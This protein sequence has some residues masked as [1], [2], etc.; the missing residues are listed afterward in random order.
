MKNKLFL[1]LLAAIGLAGSVQAQTTTFV[2]VANLG[3]GVEV[4]SS[5]GTVKVNATVLTKNQRWTRDRVYILANN[6]IVKSGV[7]LTIEPGT[8]IRAEQAT[9]GQGSGAEAA[10]TPA[11][12]GALVVARG[13]RL[14]AAGTADAPIIFTSIDDPNVPGGIATIPV[15]ENLGSTA[16][17]GSITTNTNSAISNRVHTITGATNVT[18]VIRVT[19]ATGGTT[20]KNLTNGEVFTFTN[21]SFVNATNWYRRVGSTTNWYSHPELTT[22]FSNI[23]AARTLKTGVTPENVA[24]NSQGRPGIYT[25]TGTGNLTGTKGYGAWASEADS[26][27][28]HDGLWGGIV[29]AGNATVVRGYGYN[30]N[31]P[32]VFTNA[33]TTSITVPTIDPATGVVSGTQRGVQQIE[34]MAGFE[35]YAWGGG[36][37]VNPPDDSGILRFISNRYGGFIIA[38][39]AELNSYSFYGVGRGTVLEFLEAWNN[40]DDDFEF[41]GG[42]VNMRYALSLFCG[43]DGLDTDQGFLGAIQYY[44]QIQNNGVGNESGSVVS[45]RSSVNYGDSLTENDGPESENRTVPL[46]TYILSNATLVGRGYGSTGSWSNAIPLSGPN[47]KDNAGARW[48]NSIIMDNPHGAVLITDRE[49][50][51]AIDVTTALEGSSIGRFAFA[52]TNGG[53]DGAGRAIDLVNATDAASD[54]PDGRFHSCMFFRNGLADNSAHGGEVGKYANN[55]AFR[56]AETNDPTAYFVGAN[57]NLF[58]TFHTHS[59][60]GGANDTATNRANT[61]AV[62]AQLTNASNHNSFNTDPGLNV[63]P[64]TRL[65]GLDMR[66]SA[67]AA[68][69]LTNSSIPNVRGLNTNATYAGAVLDNA[70]MR[71]WTISDKL[72]LWAGTQYVPEVRISVIGTNPMITFGA[73]ANI[74]Y[75]VERSTD[76][77]SYVPI[78][79]VP[80]GLEDDDVDLTDTGTILGSSPVFYRVIAR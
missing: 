1:T 28:R 51:G 11:D 54:A 36:D 69:S 22:T 19:S 37:T 7:T 46:S 57:G 45:G 63:N 6:V 17:A 71:G 12:P 26:A 40:A 14:I 67:T 30:T 42:D 33:N 76:N 50:N 24:T 34:G 41:W 77:K 56:F 72:G 23:V 39:N 27:W 52:R 35:A 48:H 73:E 64:Y 21:Y 74:S 68:R 61:A 75:V 16:A 44:V 62:I 15:Y 53:F 8:L 13:G 31:T 70:W 32:T 25:V 79:T 60:R 49:T 10:L 59:Q 66:P 65:S 3:D 43:D 18:S 80:A 55:A 4:L 29:L 20:T 47:Y 9:I 58:P 78:A 2:D 5:G 38:A